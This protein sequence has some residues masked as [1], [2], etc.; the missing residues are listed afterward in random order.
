MQARQGKSTNPYLKTKVMTATPQELRLM[1]YEGVLRFCRQAQDALEQDKLEPF[2][3]AL[4]RAHK[5]VL[6]LSTSLRSEAAPELCEKLNALYVYIY[7]LLVDASVNRDKKALDEALDLL[8]YEKQTWEMLMDKLAKEGHGPSATP[9]S[10]DLTGAQQTA[11]SS[12]SID[13]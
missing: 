7:R 13:G 11:I 4:T 10:T 12:L 5:I 2:Y 1:L 3:N 6:E 9:Q 8:T